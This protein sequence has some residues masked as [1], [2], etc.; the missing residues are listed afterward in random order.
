MKARF[1]LVMIAGLMSGMSYGADAALVKCTVAALVPAEAD[2]FGGNL[3]VPP[4]VGATIVL[5]LAATEIT[6]L[7]F[8]DGGQLALLAVRAKLTRLETP[9]TP[10][11]SVFVGTHHGRITG[12]YTGQLVLSST[13]ADIQVLHAS[14]HT[15]HQMALTCEPEAKKD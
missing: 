8:S 12:D 15:V 1:M 14:S 5:D 7:D 10:R 9:A 3:A 13:G 6:S 4:A 11:L 2:F